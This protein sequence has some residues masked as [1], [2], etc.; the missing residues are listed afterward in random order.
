MGRRRGFRFSCSLDNV[1]YSSWHVPQCLFLHSPSL[2]SPRDVLHPHTTCALCKSHPL[3]N[4]S[5]LSWIHVGLCQGMWKRSRLV[6]K[7]R[8]ETP[9]QGMRSELDSAP[10]CRFW[11]SSTK[12]KS[13]RVS[14]ANTTLKAQIKAS[15]YSMWEFMAWQSLS[16]HSKGPVEFCSVFFLSL[17]MTTPS[18]ATSYILLKT[19]ALAPLIF[20]PNT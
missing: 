16:H 20:H 12:A 8:L 9:T 13:T 11:R 4:G 14:E 17:S 19:S 5:I 2:R 15:H 1:T 18:H 10:G 3:C 7:N 6:G